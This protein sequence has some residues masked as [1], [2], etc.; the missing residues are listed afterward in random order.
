MKEPFPFEK[1]RVVLSTQGRDRGRYFLVL[2]NL[3]SERVA[4]ADGRTHRLANPKKK[5][6]RHLQAKPNVVNFDT[7]RPEGGPIQ[8]SDLRR[9]LEA[10]GFAVDCSL[11]EEG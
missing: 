5:N 7:V 9:A 4:V 2:E 1:G 6:I 3:G 8:D 11:C 10:C